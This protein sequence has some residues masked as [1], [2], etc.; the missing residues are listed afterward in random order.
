MTQ[1]KIVEEKLLADG[2]VTNFWAIDSRTTLRL[3]D[4]IFKLRNEGW[5]FSTES[6][7][8]G[9]TK[10][11]RYILVSAPKPVQKTLL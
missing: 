8:I 10:N 9:D 11:W 1:K 3:G 2:F 4:I 6:G 5:E 7:Y